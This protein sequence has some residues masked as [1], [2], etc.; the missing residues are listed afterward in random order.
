M[1]TVSCHFCM[2]SFYKG[3]IAT[4]ELIQSHHREFLCFQHAY[5][6]LRGKKALSSVS[7]SAFHFEKATSH[8]ETIMY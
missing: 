1:A 2:F 7:L 5:R 8:K 4:E 6:I 3:R